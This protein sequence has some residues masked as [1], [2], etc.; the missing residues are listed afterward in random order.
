M[1]GLHGNKRNDLEAVDISRSESE[2][3]DN[4]RAE[5]GEDTTTVDGT[6]PSLRSSA[7]AHQKDGRQA[8][9]LAREETNAV[10]KLKLVVYLVLAL[11]AT[12]V[13]LSKFSYA[14]DR[15]SKCGVF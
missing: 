5:G 13:A 1:T 14:L 6:D 8:T 12:A 11:S 4:D 15:Q 3:G 7:D 10:R 2:P 9:S